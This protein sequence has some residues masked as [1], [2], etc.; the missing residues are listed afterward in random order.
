LN[1]STPIVVERVIAAPPSVVYAYLTESEKWARWQG[2]GATIQSTPGGVF[3]LTMPAGATAQGEFVDLVPGQR[4]V[5]TWGWV[6]HPSVPPGSTTVE[7]ELIAEGSSTRIRLTHTGL[8]PEEV[9]IHAAGWNRYLPRLAMVS[10]G[11]DPGPDR[12]DAGDG[13]GRKPG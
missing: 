11:F 7:I 3:A 5:F 13:Q 6:G 9:P 8:P 10:E 1:L 2:V 12:F 4:V